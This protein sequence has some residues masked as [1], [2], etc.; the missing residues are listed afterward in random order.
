MSSFAHFTVL[1]SVVMGL[2]VWFVEPVRAQRSI[3]V[4]DS[5]G[6]PVPAVRIDVFGRGELIAVHS[7]SEEGWAELASDRWSDVRRISLSHLGFRTRIVQAEEL[8]SDGVIRLE[9]EALSIE[10]LSVTGRELCPI[11]AT[12]EARQL[13]SEMAS[14]YSSETESRALSAFVSRRS[15]SAASETPGNGATPTCIR[16]RLTTSRIQP[17]A[18][19]TTSRSRTSPRESRR[20]CSVREGTGTEGAFAGLFGS[21]RKSAS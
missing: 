13:W 17:S 16:R 5:F 4:V 14:L 15:I 18:T 21:I 1:V 20:W 12:D 3:E 6:R 2:M 19:C 11:D 7:T 8:P 9:P 10:G